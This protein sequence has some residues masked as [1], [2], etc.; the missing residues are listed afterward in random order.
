MPSRAAAALLLLAAAVQPASAEQTHAQTL[1]QQ[2]SGLAFRNPAGNAPAT[3]SNQLSP[4]STAD[5]W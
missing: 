1:Y 2:L 4:Q 5:S 3:S